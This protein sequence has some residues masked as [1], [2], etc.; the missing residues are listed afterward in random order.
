ML[1][2]IMLFGISFIYV[3]LLGIQTRAIIVGNHKAV[4]CI[5]MLIGAASY[6]VYSNAAHTEFLYF[7]F[8]S[9]FGGAVGISLT[10]KYR[11]WIKT[12][13]LDRIGKN[14]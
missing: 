3:G 12:N 6:F 8:T 5:S 14:S 13:I 9:A 2:G 7:I 10:V 1:N 11:E 4:F